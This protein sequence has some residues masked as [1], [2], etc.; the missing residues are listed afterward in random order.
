MLRA[1]QTGKLN[2]WD[3]QWAYAVFN[4]GG[5]GLYPWRSLVWNSGVGCGTHGSAGR[6]IID[7]RLEVVHGRL[8]RADFLKPRLG[9][10]LTFP[11]DVAVDEGAFERLGRRLRQSRSLP[12]LARRLMQKIWRRFRG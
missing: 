2:T 3:V 4:R 12:N 11:A 5:L 7:E 6:T 1:T 10:D 8:T 9:P